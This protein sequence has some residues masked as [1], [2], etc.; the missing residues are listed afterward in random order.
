MKVEKC[1][2]GS[3]FDAEHPQRWLIVGQSESG[4]TNAFIYSFINWMPK[5]DKI[6]IFSISAKLQP[7]IWGLLYDKFADDWAQ[8]HEEDEPPDFYLNHEMDDDYLT[9]LIDEQIFLY[10]ND[11]M[12]N[13]LVVFDDMLSEGIKGHDNT[14]PIEKIACTGRHYGIFSCI[15]AQRL[16]G[17][18]TTVR[19]QSNLMAFRTAREQTK[20]N[21][22][23]MCGF[24]KKQEFYDMLSKIWSVDYRPFIFTQYPK[25]AYYIGYDREIVLWDKREPDDEAG[26]AGEPDKYTDN[27]PPEDATGASG[28]A[29]IATSIQA[30][31]SILQES[32]KTDKQ[33]EDTTETA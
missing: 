24:G 20:Q 1:E 3:M 17:V 8:T 19:E 13:V 32:D 11:I 9:K 31:A 12:R 22:F 21:I 23:D 18:S 6:V 28:D 16:I 14:R 5:F 30:D 33:E 7:Q 15:L 26:P 10:E 2:I 29:H 4:K 27:A 25:S